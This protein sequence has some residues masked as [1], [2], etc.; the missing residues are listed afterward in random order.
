MHNLSQ[1]E[2]LPV[3]VPHSPM[4]R[5]P[6]LS[7]SSFSLTMAPTTARAG[8]RNAKTCRTWCGQDESHGSQ[9][10]AGGAVL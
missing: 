3:W 10:S 2:R 5:M 8:A 4:I 6:S 1:P 7:L 9:G